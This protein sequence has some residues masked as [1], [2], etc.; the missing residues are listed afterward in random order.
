MSHLTIAIIP[1]KPK[2]KKDLTQILSRINDLNIDF[3]SDTQTPASI[4]FMD[5]NTPGIETLLPQIRTHCQA[6]F[7]VIPETQSEV[8]EALLQNQ[9]DDVVVTP[10]RPLEVLGKLKHYQNILLWDEVSR[11]NESFSSLVNR[12]H[13]DLK[14]AERLQKAQL[15]ARFPNVRGF[16]IMSRYLAGLRSGG[17]YFDVA[18]S[19]QGSRLALVLTDA[20]TYGLASTVI[21]VLMRVAL[22]LTADEVRSSAETVEKIRAELL[23]T[24]GEKDFLSLFYGVISKKDLTLNY[25]NLGNT[26]IF[27]SA[28]DR[29]FKILPTQGGTI[30][31]G[32]R[33]VRLGDENKLQ[34]EPAD[35]LVLISDGFIET[36]GGPEHTARL[37]DRFRKTDP[38]DALNEFVY[39]V[40]S[41]FK[42]PDDVPEQ[43]CTGIVIDIPKKTLRLAS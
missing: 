8:P 30:S 3:H 18:E 2:W 26:R 12:L 5:A 13:D 11:V 6:V 41:R 14:L 16:E 20:S 15:P 24:L 4:A 7:L 36:L 35:R 43:D 33:L 22:K 38:K 27:H 39:A 1:E 34:L 40:K 25:I 32:N 17:D 28:K 42:D 37:L 31:S 10:L 19:P 23:T 21:S 9:V 29:P